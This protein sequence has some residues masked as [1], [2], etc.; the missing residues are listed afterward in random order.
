MHGT[1]HRSFEKPHEV[2][3]FP[4]TRAEI[5]KAGSGEI[6]RLGLEPGWRWSNDVKPIGHDAWVIENEPVV[7]GWF[8]AGNYAK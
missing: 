8:G 5:V 6:G 1:E 3:E 2:G 7:V 4:N